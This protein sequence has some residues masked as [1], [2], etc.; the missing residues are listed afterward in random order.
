M[1]R[2]PKIFLAFVLAALLFDSVEPR[3]RVLARSPEDSAIGQ[4][5][6]GQT[7][8]SPVLSSAALSSQSIQK[9]TLKP[10]AAT[11]PDIPFDTA[12]ASAEQTLLTLANQSRRQAGAPPLAPDPGL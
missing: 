4:S 1:Q 9:A 8:P 10:G 11:A 5:S 12:E 3:T 6:S 2:S 7:S